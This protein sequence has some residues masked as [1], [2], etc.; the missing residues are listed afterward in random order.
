MASRYDE[1]IIWKRLTVSSQ[2]SIFSDID[3]RGCHDGRIGEVIFV[4]DQRSLSER[5][6]DR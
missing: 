5:W 3:R 6:L 2:D 4:I 1:V